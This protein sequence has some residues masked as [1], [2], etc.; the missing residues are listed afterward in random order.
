M[1]FEI[2]KIIY[3]GRAIVYGEFKDL[4]V[5]G[6]VV[7]IWAKEEFVGIVETRFNGGAVVRLV[8]QLHL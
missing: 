1:K 4:P 7:C 5:D 3:G 8:Q 2:D 6:E